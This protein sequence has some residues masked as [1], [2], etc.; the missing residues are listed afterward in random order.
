MS[1]SYFAQVYDLLTENVEYSERA[2]YLCSLLS[3]NGID[4]GLLLDL[5]CGTGSMS[6]ELSKRGFEVTGVDLSEEMLSQAQNKMYASGESIL[7]L[8]QDMRALDLYGTVDCAV[9]TLDSLNHLNDENDLKEAFR[10]VALFLEDNGIFIFDM[11]TLYKHR[12]ILADNAYIYEYDGLFCAWQ[13]T[14]CEDN[15]T[16]RI[17]LDFFEQ[18]EG[19]TYERFSESFK[20]KAYTD[21]TVEKLLCETGFELVNRYEEMTKHEPTET[22]QRTVYVARRMPR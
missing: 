9:C 4:R 6:V 17:D 10:N 16:V 3:E 8:C 19:D 2:D 7:F 13:N 15:A 20:E 18:T 5:A 22:T 21:E 14:L 12:K 1:Y 11:N